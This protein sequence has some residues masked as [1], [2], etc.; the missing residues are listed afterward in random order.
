MFRYN[1]NEKSVIFCTHMVDFHRSSHIHWSFESCKRT[2][3]GYEL[4]Y[5]NV[6]IKKGSFDLAKECL[7]LA[8]FTWMIM[9]ADG[10][11]LTHTACMHMHTH[12]HTPTHAHTHTPTHAH[13]HPR[14]HMHTHAC[15]HKHTHTHAYTHIHTHPRM[16][17][18]TH[19]HACTHAP[20]RTH[21]HTHTPCD[22]MCY[23]FN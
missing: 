1:K 3:E 15:T 11:S 21:A 7:M 16:H 22:H 17:T 9:E 8:Y 13:V 10:T 19:T 5:I 23:N 14:M 12:T 6:L 2:F 20:A 4:T 18:S